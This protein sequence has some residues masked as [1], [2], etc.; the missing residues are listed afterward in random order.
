MVTR[1]ADFMNVE[2]HLDEEQITELT[3]ILEEDI[4]RFVE[5]T[6][7]SIEIISKSFKAMNEDN[8]ESVDIVQDG[9]DNLRDVFYELEML[10]YTKILKLYKFGNKHSLDLDIILPMISK[11]KG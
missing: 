2:K 8:E 7:K 6:D 5:I 9:A 4:E 10:R 1:L 3:E 11:L